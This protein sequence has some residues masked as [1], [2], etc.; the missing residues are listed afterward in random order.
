MSIV[1]YFICLFIEL[2]SHRNHSSIVIVLLDYIM[3]VTIYVKKRDRQQSDIWAHIAVDVCCCAGGAARAY[4]YS[5]LDTCRAGEY[6]GF[7]YVKQQNNDDE[8]ER[9]NGRAWTIVS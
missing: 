8:D 1:R 4:I 3:T 5:Q 6:Y 7:C 9:Y 2:F